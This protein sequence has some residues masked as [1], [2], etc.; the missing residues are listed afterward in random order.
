MSECWK[1]R[2]LRNRSVV[3]EDEPSKNVAAFNVDGKG[4]A[5]WRI[6]CDRYGH[7]DASVRALFVVMTYVGAQDAF[8]VATT[9]EEDRS[10][11]SAPVEYSVGAVSGR[12]SSPQL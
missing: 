2:R 3:H 6:F 9:D 1:S 8:S 10:L 12:S 7:A 11:T 4:T 5:A